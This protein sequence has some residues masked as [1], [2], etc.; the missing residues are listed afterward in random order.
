MILLGVSIARPALQGFLGMSGAPGGLASFFIALGTLVT[1]VVIT[2]QG[3]STLKLYT[4]AVGALTGVL[5][6]ALFGVWDGATLQALSQAAAVGLPPLKLAR[7]AFDASLLPLAIVMGVVLAVDNDGMLVGIQRQRDPA[8]RRID[9]AHAAVGIQASAVGDVLAGLFA[10]MPTGISSANVGLAYATGVRSRTVPLLVGAVMVLATF[11]PKLLL[12]MSLVPA[13]VVSAVVVFAACYMMVSGMEL[14]FARIL[15]ERRM[16][17]IGLSLAV[18]LSPEVFGALIDQGKVPV[19]LQPILQSQLATALIAAIALHSLFRIGV[20]EHASFTLTPEQKDFYPP[21]RDFL[22]GLGRQWGVRRDVVETAV[23]AG[24]DL[25]E[26]LTMIDARVEPVAVS[27]RCDD[28]WFELAF[29][30]RG[31]ALQFPSGPLPISELE[32]DRAALARYA[33]YL[34]SATPDELQ[35]RQSGGRQTVTLRFAN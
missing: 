25:L 1:M 4:L 22:G 9:P 19:M 16:L 7:P 18:G 5:L 15:N 27:A 11:S 32:G 26:A 28:S 2:L 29:S 17:T 8:W 13:P 21:I 33:A 31:P 30:Y 20:A 34:A 3:R 14:L 23:R 6:S 35:A 10:G 24:A 12:A